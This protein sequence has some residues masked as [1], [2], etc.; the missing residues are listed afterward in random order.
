MSDRL[1]KLCRHKASGRYYVTLNGAEVYLGTNRNGAIVAFGGS[2][3]LQ[4]Y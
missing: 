1:P 2:N 4:T 3:G